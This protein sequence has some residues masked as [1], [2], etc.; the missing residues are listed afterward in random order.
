MSF[1]DTS[2]TCFP[3]ARQEK[4]MN[5]LYVIMY[6]G[7]AASSSCQTVCI[8]DSKR[9]PFIVRPLPIVIIIGVYNAS[10]CS[11]RATTPDFGI[12]ALYPL[13][14]T[15]STTFEYS[16]ISIIRRRGLDFFD[17]LASLSA[18]A[19][20]RALFVEDLVF[21]PPQVFGGQL[22]VPRWP[23]SRRQVLHKQLVAQLRGAAPPDAAHLL[24]EQLPS[25]GTGAWDRVHRP[26]N[27][28]V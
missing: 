24:S 3:R 6:S 19:L 9:V 8:W 27:S 25:R 5:G 22:S 23:K 17:R 13:H 16:K 7:P 11:K 20:K 21:E 15:R 10:V 28:F 1:L 18:L 2:T 4:F 26:P 12:W 14:S